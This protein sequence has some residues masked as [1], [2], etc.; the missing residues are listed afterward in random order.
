MHD[1]WDRR[2]RRS[3]RHGRL[4][5]FFAGSLGGIAAAVL[6]VVLP[7]VG[8]LALLAGLSIATYRGLRERDRSAEWVASIG[9][10]LFASGTLFLLMAANVYQACSR[11][12]DS[13]G[14][15]NPLPLAVVGVVL[16][17][18]GMIAAATAARF[19]P[20]PVM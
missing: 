16:L 9:G 20:G 4:R 19:R 3:A 15:A 13:C 11:T 17:V 10:L 7:A 5:S 8:L 12:A 2:A 1:R 6:T 14:R 18:A